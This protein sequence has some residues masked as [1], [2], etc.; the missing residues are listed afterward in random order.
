MANDQRVKKVCD[1]LT[2]N[3][4]DI[5]LVGRQLQQSL[6]INRP[7]STVRFKLIFNKGA[8]FYME[9]NLSLFFFSF[10]QDEKITLDEDEK[11]RGF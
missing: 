11:S 6:N 7:Y 4:F 9:Y 5:T 3:N 10:M 2:K 1:T 8:L